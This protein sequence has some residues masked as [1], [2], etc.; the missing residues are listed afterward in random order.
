[1]TDCARS[2][3]TGVEDLASLDPLNGSD[4]ADFLAE[5]DAY[6]TVRATLKNMPDGSEDE[7]Y[8]IAECAERWNRV[9]RARE[10]IK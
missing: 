2:A 8:C 5:F 9:L 1:M 3:N 7:R 4:L 10:N 6:Q